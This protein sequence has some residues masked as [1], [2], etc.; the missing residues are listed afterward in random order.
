[1][2]SCGSAGRTGA[3]HYTTRVGSAYALQF[4]DNVPRILRH[5]DFSIH[6][7]SQSTDA[8]YVETSWREREV[9]GEEREGGVI[10]AQSRILVYGRPVRTGPAGPGGDL[11]NIDVRIENQVETEAGWQRVAVTSE[12]LRESFRRILSDFQME[13]GS[14]VREF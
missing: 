8:L 4:N 13:F 12:P 10:R 5:H 9:L 2:A 1:M 3:G 11:Y 14:G 6:R 7:V